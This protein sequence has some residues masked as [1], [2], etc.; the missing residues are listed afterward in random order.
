[1][2]TQPTLLQPTPAWTGVE[3]VGVTTPEALAEQARAVLPAA[4][5]A[6]YAAGSGTGATV[7]EQERAW[8]SAALRPRI[9]RDVSHVDPTTT[10]LRSQVSSPVLLAPSAAHA[11]AHAHGELPAA[12]AARGAG[13]PRRGQ[14]AGVVHALQH[15]PG[16][17]GR[18]GGTVVAT[19][20]CA[21]RPRDLRRGRPPSSSSRSAC[22]GAHR[23]HPLCR[24]EGRRSAALRAGQG[25]HP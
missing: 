21:A 9:L 19:N 12:Q 23:R 24:Q 25:G 22:S 20:L 2:V 8:S 14:P 5:Y 7:N 15:S 18:A 10:V 4:V 1:M 13:C 6:Y 3:N 17:G 11:L 16:A